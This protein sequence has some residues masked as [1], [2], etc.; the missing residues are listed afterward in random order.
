MTLWIAN[1]TVL[2]SSN[3]WQLKEFLKN[4]SCPELFDFQ[5]SFNCH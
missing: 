1:G 4:S 5:N 3:Q 2:K